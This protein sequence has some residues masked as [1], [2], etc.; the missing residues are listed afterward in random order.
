MKVLFRINQQLSNA[1]NRL[2]AT[3][4][5]LLIADVV[6]QVITRFVLAQPS[7]FTEEIARFLLIWISLLGAAIAYRHSDHLGF[8]LLTKKVDQNKQQKI[9]GFNALLVMLFAAIVLIT[10]GGNVVHI[11]YTMEQSSSVLGINMGYVYSVVPISGVLFLL[12]ATENLIK[13]KTLN[14]SELADGSTETGE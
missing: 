13:H 6:W 14:Q 12:F 3:L 10:G 8:D 1:L 9:A 5:V 2:V 7:S 11:V 4:L